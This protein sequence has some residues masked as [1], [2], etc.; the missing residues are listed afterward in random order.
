MSD[1]N[2]LWNA[3]AD[4][5]DQRYQAVTDASHDQPTP[6]AEW[7]VSDV[8]AHAVGVQAAF[9]GAL[10]AGT[11]E[12]ADWP[13]ARDAMRTALASPGATEGTAF[14]AGFGG[15][16]PKAMLV[17][18][19]TTDLLVHTWDL[20]RALGVDATLPTDSAAAALA[21]LQSL[22]AEVLRAPGRFGPEVEV[23]ADADPQTRLLAFAG[24]QP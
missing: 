3:A 18:V 5:F 23:P 10:G 2:Q 17:S 9:G 4:A 24:R 12:D 22:P 16:V 6:C 13:T 21:A 7:K 1:L 19:A 14:Y 8:V 20:A 11:A 15:E